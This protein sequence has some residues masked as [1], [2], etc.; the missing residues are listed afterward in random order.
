MTILNDKSTYNELFST[1][2][3]IQDFCTIANSVGISK[4]DFSKGI[5]L[6]IECIDEPQGVI[7]L[8]YIVKIGR[9]HV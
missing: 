5:G 9:A 2:K 4:E 8:H 3:F 1:N 6:S 7:S